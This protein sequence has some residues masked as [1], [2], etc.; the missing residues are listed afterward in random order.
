MTSL[1]YFTTFYTV[2]IVDFEKVNVSRDP[3]TSIFK[4]HLKLY[5]SFSNGIKSGIFLMLIVFF[6]YYV[7][8]FF[9][10]KRLHHR[11]LT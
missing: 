2:S 5:F 11:C 7:F 10:Q 1:T 8:K 6:I 3:E 9:C 4:L